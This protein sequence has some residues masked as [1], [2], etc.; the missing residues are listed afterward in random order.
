MFEEEDALGALG[1]AVES[2]LAPF[3]SC[4]ELTFSGCARFFGK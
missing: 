2:C 1:E 4:C 3:V